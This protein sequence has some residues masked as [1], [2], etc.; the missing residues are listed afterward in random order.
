VASRNSRK[1]YLQNT[2][3]HLYNRGVNKRSLFLDD[4]DYLVFLNL[5]K[6]YLSRKPEVD[7]KNREYPWLYN[8]IELLAFCLMP[9]HF[10]LL[11]YQLEEDAIKRLVKNVCGTYTI[12]FNKKYRRIGPLFQDRFKASM[13]LDE[14]YLYH[15]SRYIH[16]NPKNYLE[17][18]YSSM[19]F[20]TGQKKAEWLQPH[21][22]LEL[23]KDPEDYLLF[24]KDYEDQKQI[25]DEIKTS[26]ANY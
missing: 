20:Y 6:R 24:V 8:D 14:E 4:E 22:I 25:L 11:V 13:I 23:F 17:W 21:R 7:Y 19:H 3:Y 16:L 18:P 15:I 5:F 9:N 26:L 2:H 1:I 12:Y 10:H